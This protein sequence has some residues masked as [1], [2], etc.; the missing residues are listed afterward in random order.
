[1]YVCQTITFESRDVGSSYLHIQ[2]IAREYGS[3]SCMKVIGSRSSRSQEQKGPKSLFPPGA[4][5]EICGWGG[6]RQGGL[7]AEALFEK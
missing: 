7:E 1:M 3:S 6:P 5:L 4:A 2:Y